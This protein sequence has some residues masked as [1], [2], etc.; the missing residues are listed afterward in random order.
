MRFTCLLVLLIL[1][2]WMPSRGVPAPFRP[3]MLPGIDVS[4]YQSRIDWATVMATH[5][6]E[7]AFVKATEGHEYVDSLF[8]RNWDALRQLDVRRGA[9]HFFRAQGCGYEQALHFLTTVGMQPGD[10]VPVLDVELTDGAAPE[11]LREEVFIWLQTVEAELHVKPI[12]YSN[13]HFYDKYL[14]GWFDQYPLWVARYS[15]EKPALSTGRSWQFWQYSNEG[16]LDGIAH[17][18]DLNLFAGTPAMLDALRW[19]PPVAPA[20]PV[21]EAS[22]AP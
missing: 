8:C 22:A 5:P 20:L 4:H 21:A 13:Q 19:F 17:K 2:A 12:I 7:F 3:E 11:I 6:L 16:S 9:Y 10:L 14:A 15:T 1:P 18:T